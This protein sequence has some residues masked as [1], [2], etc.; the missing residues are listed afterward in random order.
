M[1][2]IPVFLFEEHHEAFFVWH[3]SLLNK[4]IPKNNNTLLHID[5]HSDFSIPLFNYSIHSLNSNLRDIYD[6]T[7]NELTIANFIVPAVYQGIFDRVDWLYQSNNEGKETERLMAVHSYKGAGTMMRINTNCQEDPMIFFKPGFKKLVMKIL[8][9]NDNFINSP[10]VVLDIDLDYFS[11][12]PAHLYYQGKVE[13]T[14]QEF[15]SFN[16]NEHHFL[17]F[18]LGSG[19][20]C[21][22]ENGKY[23]LIFSSPEL[24][25]MNSKLKVSE[26]EILDR[27]DRFI[28]F[29]KNNQVQP[30]MIDI[31]RSRLSGFTPEDQCEFIEKNLLE[32]LSSLYPLHL[33][34]L[35]EVLREEKLK[36]Y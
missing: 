2:A 16:G 5:E 9:T 23:Y 28:D 22:V 4:L 36:S 13:I 14:E 7:R 10:S 26:D 11:C 15:N 34:H 8:Q 20:K 17:R 12:N 30:A 24:E 29:L 32:K 27:I 31:C 21:K 18:S 3:Y 6:F 25:G 33:N 1:T 19:I 35:K